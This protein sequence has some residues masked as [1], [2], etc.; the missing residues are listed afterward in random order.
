[1]LLPLLINLNMFGP[2]I[3][4]IPVPVTIVSGGVA[5]FSNIAD[6]KRQPVQGF[7]GPTFDYMMRQSLERD[8]TRQVKQEDEDILLFIKKI[9]S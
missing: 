4:P 1:M 5:Q 6:L 9:C 7:T 2:P 3:P 8:V